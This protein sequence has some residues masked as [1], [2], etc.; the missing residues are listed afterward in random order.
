MM[1]LTHLAGNSVG[2]ADLVAPVATTNRHNGQ[3]GKNNRTSNSS[4]YFLRT[5]HSQANVP[6]EVTDCNKC[7]ENKIIKPCLRLSTVHG[8]S[9]RHYAHRK[10][11]VK[12]M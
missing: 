1:W 9:H 2:F 3:L 8:S 5:L 12:L 10:T 6:V 4:C 11:A 7:L